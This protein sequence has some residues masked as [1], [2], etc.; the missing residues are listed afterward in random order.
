MKI[1][2]YFLY[3]LVG[4]LLFFPL[5]KV[6]AQATTT[7]EVEGFDS[8]AEHIQNFDT[9]VNV[10]KDSSIDVTEK[11]TYVFADGDK[12]HGIY[13][14]IPLKGLHISKILVM[15][16]IGD[17]LQH[18]DSNSG[19]VEHLK[20]GS[21][22]VLLSGTYEYY[23]HYTVNDAIGY[24]KDY[25]EIYW[26]AT[27]NDSIYPIYHSSQHI[28]LPGNIDQKSLRISCYWGHQGI[29]NSCNTSSVVSTSSEYTMIDFNPN[30]VLSPLSG[31]TVAVGFPK[32][33]TVEPTGS[34]RFFYKIVDYIVLAV[35]ILIFLIVFIFMF[36]KWYRFGRDPK[37]REVIVAEYEVPDNLSPMEVDGILHQS[38]QS[39]SVS[40]E[41]I[42][43][44][45]NGYLK[46][47]RCENNLL[48][49]FNLTDYKLIRLKST[50]DNMSEASKQLMNSLF[51]SVDA[52]ASVK[53]SDLRNS[54]YI[55]VSSIK[56]LVSKNLTTKGY[57]SGNPITITRPY[58]VAGSLFFGL[59][60]FVLFV[61]GAIFG[62]FA[63]GYISLSLFLSFLVI[64][65]FGFFMPKNT[66]K[67][68]ATRDSIL[69]LKEYLQI[70][71]KDRINFANAPEK[72][73]EIFEKFLPYAMVLGV[74]KAWAKEFEGIYVT[75]PTWYNDSH[76]KSFSTSA[77]VGSLGTFHSVAASSLSSSPS[78]HSGSGGGGF[79]GGGGGGGSV[80]S[81]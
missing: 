22:D 15:G 13:R 59:S 26:N 50:D 8:T 63:P 11:I 29:N 31:V 24:F 53:L 46:I 62:G 70:V 47:E 17:E 80:G 39:G 18:I 21:P 67:G 58:L 60:I 54:F 7:D 16:G 55:V 66:E 41:I 71:E 78:S 76:M 38:I 65:T 61:G 79:S 69:G 49:V 1:K 5:V 75:P 12:K 3:L 52:D 30:Q 34:A 35:S 36:Q 27:G 81:W 43:L 19:G 74:E 37:G 23:I 32:G 2:N 33:I 73:P 40:A 10:N 45:I 68:V 28:I 51:S 57:Y 6:N 64:V 77:F 9:T 44:A 14:D 4:F 20:I 56:N 48:G 25:D 72:K 42:N